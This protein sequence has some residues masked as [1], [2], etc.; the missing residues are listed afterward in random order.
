VSENRTSVEPETGS[1]GDAP[2]V[3]RGE[4]QEAPQGKRSRRGRVHQ[5]LHAHPALALTTK[6]VVTA[7]GILV[8]GAGLLMMVTPGPGIV[9]IAVG[10]AILA[11]EW[12]WADRWLVAARRKAHEAKLKAE[13]MDPKV[14]RRRIAITAL[15]TVLVATAVIVYVAL[16]DWPGP[17]VSGWNWLQDMA[18]WVPELPGM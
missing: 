4:V 3:S 10:L 8:I 6:I 16:Y 13:A 15:V 14:R 17:A 2:G 9:A 1:H 11:T 12:D 18:G 5:K 7:V